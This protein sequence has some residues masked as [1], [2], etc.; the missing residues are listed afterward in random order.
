MSGSTHW[1]QKWVEP[2]SSPMSTDRAYEPM[3]P[4]PTYGHSLKRGWIVDGRLKVLHLMDFLVFQKAHPDWSV[5][6]K[7]HGHVVPQSPIQGSVCW[8][9]LFSCE[10]RGV[11]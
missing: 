2:I 4:G 11:T 10:F 1:V 7:F 5:M 3:D 8:V 6:L 9:R